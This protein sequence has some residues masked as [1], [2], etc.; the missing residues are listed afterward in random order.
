MFLSWLQGVSEWNDSFQISTLEQTSIRV[1]C[2]LF[3]L[4]DAISHRYW[5]YLNNTVAIG[6]SYGNWRWFHR[7]NVAEI[8][9]NWFIIT[10][11]KTGNKNKF[12]F[13]DK[14]QIAIGE[15]QVPNRWQRFE[16]MNPTRYYQQR[17][18]ITESS[19]KDRLVKYYDVLYSLSP[20]SRPNDVIFT[21][22]FTLKIIEHVE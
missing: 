22:T 18:N 17:K 15:G 1:Q 19:S 8:I 16:S 12:G 7:Q 14:C 4:K 10:F 9:W 20:I 13:E 21:F 5:S 11:Q 6:E 2:G 3:Y